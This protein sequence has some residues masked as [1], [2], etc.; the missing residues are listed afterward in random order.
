MLI[1]TEAAALS[2]HIKTLKSENKTIGLVPTMGALHQGHISL[3]DI[4]KMHCDVVVCSIFVNPTQFNNAS[5][6]EKYPIT[7]AQDKLLLAAAHCDILFLP[8]VNEIY[9]NGTINLKQYDLGFI[10]TVYD[11][12]FRPGHFQGVCNVVEHLFRIVTPHQAFF[13]LKDYQ[14]CM[15]IT[16]LVQL[17]GWQQQLQLQLCN[18]LREKD[19]L[20]MSSRNM[21]L[22]AAARKIAPIVY[23]TMEYIK[24]NIQTGDLKN[25]LSNAHKMLT[26]QGLQPDYID[27][28]DALTLAPV[29][30]WDGKQKIVCLVAA[31]LTDVRLIDNMV[32]N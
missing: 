22:S 21:R 28:A 8:S 31:F 9:K 4:A 5:D 16:K 14:Q 6:F 18:T 13:G 29:N 11:G 17:M 7:I 12:A 24:Q 2:L 25:L 15:V 10:E 20:A 23:K 32:L 19:G 30:N 3:I 26:N 1:I 27:I